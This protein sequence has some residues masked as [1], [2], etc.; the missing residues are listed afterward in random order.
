MGIFTNL[1]LNGTTP[2]RVQ[3][4]VGEWGPDKVGTA[5]A[6]KRMRI[7]VTLAFLASV[8]ALFGLGYYFYKAFMGG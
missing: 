6:L 7:W 1:N 2:A 4:K 5:G 8:A 3:P